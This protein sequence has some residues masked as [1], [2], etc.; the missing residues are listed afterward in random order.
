MSFL[1]NQIDKAGDVRIK[2]TQ[3]DNCRMD[4][5][6]VETELVAQ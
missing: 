4:I 5:D 3:S 6:Y 1:S 2:W